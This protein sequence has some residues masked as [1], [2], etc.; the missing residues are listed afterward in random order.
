[1][2]LV[3]A[4]TVALVML[5]GFN[6]FLLFIAFPHIWMMLRLRSAI[7]FS[8]GLTAVLV[9]VPFLQQGWT[10]QA[11]G[12]SVITGGLSVGM[13]V[14]FGLWVSGI[15]A[16]SERRREL[17]AELERAR[18][19]LAGAHHREGVLAERERVAAEIHD[20]LAQGFM[21]IL[22]LAQAPPAGEQLAR[23]E[24]TA[25]ENLAEARSLIEALGP[26]ELRSG[27]LADACRRIAERLH[28]ESELDVSFQ[29]LGTPA[30]LAANS[31]VVL[32]RATQEAL[33]NVIKHAAAERVEVRLSYP[34][35]GATLVVADDGR[36][37]DPATAEGFGLQGMRHRV[38][39][40]DGT[41]DIRSSPGHGTTIK[42][43]VP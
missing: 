23:I 14:L 42:V 27:T 7:W 13:G 26:N 28:T 21:S 20:T 11:I 36:G 15:I 34:D 38:A 30:T 5:D 2:A 31:E 25:R 18:A 17:I 41:L 19:E 10:A 24:R 16:E 39:Q 37:F 33:T 3:C 9:T 29:L 4:A 35:S 6:H 43:V 1:M 40:V 8:V 12:S 22:M 32:L